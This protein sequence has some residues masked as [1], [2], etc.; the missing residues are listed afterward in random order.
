M[1]SDYQM[2]AQNFGFATMDELKQTLD[3]KE[4]TILDVR[5]EAEIA[6]SGKFQHEGCQWVQ[7]AC[8]PTNVDELSHKI[9]ENKL[10]PNKK[11]PI[12]VYCRSGRRASTAEQFLKQQG[13]DR[14]L[15][16]GGYDD[17]VAMGV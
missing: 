15:N 3:Q 11:A 1:N 10:L 9:A 13:Y 7:V 12:V 8:T 2:R 6:A 5:S 16:V 17:L 4:T 14:V